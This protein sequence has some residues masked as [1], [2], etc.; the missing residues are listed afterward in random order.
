MHMCRYS[1]E[2]LEKRGVDALKGADRAVAHLLLAAGRAGGGAELDASLALV[3]RVTTQG[4]MDEDD[5]M[6][7]EEEEVEFVEQVQDVRVGRAAPHMPCT[8][9]D[10]T[11][12]SL[13][14]HFG[15]NGRRTS[16][17]FRRLPT[18]PLAG[19]PMGGP[20]GA[21]AGLQQPVAEPWDGAG[22]WRQLLGHGARRGARVGGWERSGLSSYA[23]K[24]RGRKPRRARLAWWRPW[25]HGAL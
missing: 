16:S 14:F 1:Q 4:A 10:P 13:Y 17:R 8:H 9:R 18:R 19:L 7:A 20:G 2:S 21:G 12:L 24:L 23:M 22:A 15:L 5:A 6:E 25:S 11:R 3:T